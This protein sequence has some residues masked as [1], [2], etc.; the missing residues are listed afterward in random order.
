MSLSG[1]YRLKKSYQF[2]YVYRKGKTVGNEL[3]ILH[4]ARNNTGKP[5][6]GLSVSKK[7]GKAS[8]RNLFKRRMRF[9]FA[10]LLPGLDG[11]YNYILTPR[12]K[13]SECGYGELYESLRELLGRTGEENAV[14]GHRKRGESE[15]SR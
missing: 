4:Y 9:A 1:V 5:K 12:V 15:A 8:A 6:I 3:L 2:N 10:K 7:Y 14:H 11:R 13:A